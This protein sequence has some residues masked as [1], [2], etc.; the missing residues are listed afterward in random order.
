[1]EQIFGFSLGNGKNIAFVISDLSD[2][3]NEIELN[4]Y[5]I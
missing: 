3:I 2:L 5:T 1:M 4:R